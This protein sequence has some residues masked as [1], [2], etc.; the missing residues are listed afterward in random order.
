MTDLERIA[1]NDVCDFV[2]AQGALRQAC[3]ILRAL[4]RREQPQPETPQQQYARLIAR[5]DAANR[6]E[7]IDEGW[8]P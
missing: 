7:R 2:E 1:L 3:A 4:A 5:R 8:L 6:L